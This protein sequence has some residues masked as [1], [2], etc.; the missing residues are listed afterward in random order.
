MKMPRASRKLKAQTIPLEHFR[1]IDRRAV[2]ALTRTRKYE[3]K[4]GERL[5]ACEDARDLSDRIASS[6]ARY[7]LF[8]IP[9]SI[10]VEGNHGVA[11]AETA[12]PSFLQAFVNQQGTDR[13]NGSEVLLAGAFDF[14]DV[15][16]LISRNSRDG[17]ERT[18]AC[19]HAVS[20]IVDPEV[21]T[22]VKR[23]V[24]AGKV[25]IV[26]GGGHNNCYPVIKGAAKSLHKA[27]VILQPKVNAV[28]LDAHSDFR[29]MEG[30]HSGNG[31][32]YAMEEGFLGRYAVFCLQ[33]AYNPQ[34]IVD[35]LYSHVDIDYGFFEDVFLHGRQSFTDALAKAFAFVGEHPVAVELDLDAVEG[36]LSS[37]SHPC[38]ITVL[39][40]RQYMNFAGAHPKVASLH[41]C[42][43][44]VRLAD[45]REDPSTGRLIATLVSD[46][47]RSNV[48]V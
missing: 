5:D 33:E 31:F 45:G 7:V 18:V 6:S 41:V 42:E 4:L 48:P 21:E 27:G 9:E 13:F 44:A 2:A 30:R 28:N 38:G 39:N 37:A 22:L 47:I 36:V 16:A 23:I 19:R 29:I 11:G 3:M 14:S 25:P 26:V 34:S 15:T 32:R 20:N 10:G 12:W 1:P 17:E 8:G 40:A 46:F 43:G 35:D 24:A